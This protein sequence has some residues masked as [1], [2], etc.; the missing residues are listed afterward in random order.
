MLFPASFS[1]AG[2][3]GKQTISD[4]HQ[5]GTDVGSRNELQEGKGAEYF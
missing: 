2:S 4:L 5:T 3:G 1:W